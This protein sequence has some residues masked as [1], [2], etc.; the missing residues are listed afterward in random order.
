MKIYD[1][2]K[3]FVGLIIFVA[4]LRL[5]SISTWA[6]LLLNQSL[7]LIHLRYREWKKRQGKAV[8]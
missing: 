7:S 5:H 1:G 6:R 8:R 3:I 2:G 4:L